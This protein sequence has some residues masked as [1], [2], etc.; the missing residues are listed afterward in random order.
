LA[1]LSTDYLGL[2]LANPLVPSASPL[3]M[4]LDTARRLE[5]AGAGAL[6]MQSLFEEGM[7]GPA[8]A[9]AGGSCEARYLAQLQSLKS[10]L[11]IPVIASL[12]GTSAGDWTRC[13]T[14]MQA[15]GADALELNVYHIPA[16]ASEDC[17][18]V[19]E[20]YLALLRE[21]RGRVSIPVAVK[22]SSQITA[23][24]NFACRLE[25][26]GADGLVLFNRFYQSDIDLETMEV[27]PRLTLSTS[28]ECLLR[29]R[30]VA[31][32][33]G[34]VRCSLAVT[35]GIQDA[36]DVLKSLL[37]GA[38]VAQLCSAL[39]RRGPGYLASVLEA[40]AAW[41][42][43]R[44]YESVSQ[45]RGSIRD[46]SATDSAAFLRANYVDVLESYPALPGG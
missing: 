29:I 27:V 34:R 37:A 17:C 10:A 19:E 22:L 31:I 13:A 42:D 38:D 16:S 24:V 9:S 35:G 30:W 6:V 18:Q 32:L 43:E 7:E 44:G 41:L 5:D 1:D 3:S 23:P 25:Q 12:N 33:C 4:H 8:A 28:E 45:L 11:Q 40:L 46:N 14:A 2:S 26:E 36:S 21:V 20:R 39:L 15:A